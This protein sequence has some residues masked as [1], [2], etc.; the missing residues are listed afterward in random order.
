MK[1]YRPLR[2]TFSWIACC[3]IIYEYIWPLV[4]SGLTHPNIFQA[5]FIPLK[6]P[7]FFYRNVSSSYKKMDHIFNRTTSLENILRI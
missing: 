4:L 6:A 5:I 7:V 2:S 3:Y 1:I